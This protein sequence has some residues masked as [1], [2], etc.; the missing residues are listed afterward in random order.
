[1]NTRS[2]AFARALLT[3]AAAGI[4]S[5][6]SAALVAYE[7]F[8][9][10]GTPN[11]QFANGGVGWS[12]PWNKLS[13]IPTGAVPEGLAWPG[14]PSTGGSALTAP[15]QSADYTRYSR[16][17]TPYAAPSD[18]VYISFLFRPNIG[19]GVGGG[20]AFGTWDNGMIVGLVPGTGRYGL[21]GFTGPSSVTGA[22]AV[23]GETVL[24]VARAQR[25]AGGT[26]TWSLH[27]NPA[28]GGGE[29]EAP[30]ASMTIPGT[31]LPQALNLYHDGGYST[32]EIRVATTWEEA[33]GQPAP[34]PPCS[35]DLDGDGAV[36]GAD[37]GA[38]LTQWGGPGSADLNHDGVVDGADLG[39]LL[40]VW[41][42]CA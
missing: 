7:G 33:L 42:P 17:L 21:A 4:A 18:M 10:G 26:I 15:Y 13:T 22:A 31:A 19:F 27:V 38:L 3:F 25:N 30:A 36:G 37:L 28:V 40:A 16:A 20:L 1:M 12:G 6:A 39:S 23:Q 41:G 29:P 24:L 8:A 5:H 14:L 35:G 9:Y 11:I 34:P 2:P 32:D